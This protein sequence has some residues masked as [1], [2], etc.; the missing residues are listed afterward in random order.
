MRFY[1]GSN[2]MMSHSGVHT[3]LFILIVASMSGCNSGVAPAKY[4]LPVPPV[5]VVRG[6]DI[7]R[8]LLTRLQLPS[9]ARNAA[10]STLQSNLSVLESQDAEWAVPPTEAVTTALVR[11][12]ETTIE[13]EI[14]LR[15]IARS[16]QPH[17]RV[18]VTF[19]VFARLPSNAALVEG[20]YTV[21][22]EENSYSKR[23]SFEVSAADRDMTSYMR[24]TSMA[25]SMLA[26]AI[27]ADLSKQV[28][29][30]DEDR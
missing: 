27:G 18:A 23:F 30:G 15:P 10:I 21:D 9:Y 13:G 5:V 24:A 20:Q 3:L 11:H 29:E 7:Q 17:A 12:L 2:A 25:L 1:W 26:D 16:F 8:V 28:G 22:R 19:D 6:Q 14:R 4:I